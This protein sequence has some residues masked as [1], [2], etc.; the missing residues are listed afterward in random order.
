M[1]NS[2]SIAHRAADMIYRIESEHFSP[3]LSG[4]GRL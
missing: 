1:R 4:E 3:V 2:A